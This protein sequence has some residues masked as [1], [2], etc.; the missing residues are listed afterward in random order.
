M[1]NKRPA[2]IHDSIPFKIKGSE[3]LLSITKPLRKLSNWAVERQ[4]LEIIV[5][6]NATFKDIEPFGTGAPDAPDL[7]F[8][9]GTIKEIEPSRTRAPSSKGRPPFSSQNKSQSH[10]FYNKP[11]HSKHLVA[12]L[13]EKTYQKTIG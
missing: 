6:L 5:F 8:L 7:V 11:I 9:C 4:R 13:K 3:P 12:N 10:N 2:V 1:G